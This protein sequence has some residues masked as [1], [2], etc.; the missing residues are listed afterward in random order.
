L[1]DDDMQVIPAMSLVPAATWLRAM[2]MG[3][4]WARRT[5]VKVGF[6]FA[7]KVGLGARWPSV[8]QSRIDQRRPTPKSGARF[9]ARA[10]SR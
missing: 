2:R 6:A 3:A 7:S 4:R 9:L 10:I 8:K 1:L 5:H